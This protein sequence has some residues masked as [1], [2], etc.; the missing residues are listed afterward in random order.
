MSVFLLLYTTKLIWFHITHHH[1]FE[2]F[3]STK[4]HYPHRTVWFF[5]SSLNKLSWNSMEL[6]MCIDMFVSFMCVCVYSCNG[7]L[8]Q[9]NNELRFF[10]RN[11]SV[12]FYKFIRLFKYIFVVCVWTVKQI[13]CRKIKELWQKLFR[14]ITNTCPFK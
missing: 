14:K 3:P 9:L 5:L 8:I 13:F 12:N 4:S 1:T 7:N 2:S 11:V 6:F 10:F